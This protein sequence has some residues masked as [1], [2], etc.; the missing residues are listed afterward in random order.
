M[1]KIKGISKDIINVPFLFTGKSGYYE[2]F[3]E[4]TS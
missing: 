3:A 4:T 2:I 1:A